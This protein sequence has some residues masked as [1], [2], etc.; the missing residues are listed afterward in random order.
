M[1]PMK[2]EGWILAP[3]PFGIK[4]KEGEPMGTA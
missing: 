4:G 1:A 3:A 2:K